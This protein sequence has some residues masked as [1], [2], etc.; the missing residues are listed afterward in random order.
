M[1]NWNTEYLNLFKQKTT[2][3][4]DYYIMEWKEWIEQFYK[5]YD[6][7]P[8]EFD[9][10]IS[11]REVIEDKINN[12]ELM[13]YEEHNV[14]IEKI[15]QLDKFYNKI[16]IDCSNPTSNKWWENKILKYAPEGYR[17]FSDETRRLVKPIEEL[18]NDP[19][20]KKAKEDLSKFE[21]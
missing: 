18:E 8:P 10:D 2:T 9:N 20:L 19:E 4:P 1:I 5:G 17:D 3:T 6:F 13:K 7:I 12:L 15:H 11:D 14:F 16:T 21:I